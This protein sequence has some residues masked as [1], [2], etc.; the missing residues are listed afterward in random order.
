MSVDRR[1][2]VLEEILRDPGT[3][4][5]D[6]AAAAR[7]LADLDRDARPLLASEVE[8]LPAEELLRDRARLR[9]PIR[10]PGM[11]W[12]ALSAHLL[13]TDARLSHLVEQ[14]IDERVRAGIEAAVERRTRRLVED[15]EAARR[16]EAVMRVE[17]EG[18]RGQ[19]S[20]AL[21]A[22]GQAALPPGRVEAEEPVEDVPAP[23]GRASPGGPP[24]ER[25][26]LPAA[27]ATEAGFPREGERRSG[28]LAP[29]PSRPGSIFRRG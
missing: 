23:G 3:A 11:A 4:A 8:G 24:P 27:G 13:A 18:V 28:I 7:E 16:A 10:A 26:A 15:A 6:R 2:V 14:L 9:R 5:R 22:G 19:L 29:F 1:R 20:Q 12:K 25:R 21:A 17:L